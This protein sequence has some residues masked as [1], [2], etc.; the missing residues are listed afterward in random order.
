MTTVHLLP[1][2]GSLRLTRVGV[3]VDVGVCNVS[4][5]VLGEIDSTATCQLCSQMGADRLY[6]KL[7]RQEPL[8]ECEIRV[9]VDELA[10][11]C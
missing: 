8:P 2:R 3:I 5:I 1:D 11:D 6:G 7:R 9:V 4:V 10:V